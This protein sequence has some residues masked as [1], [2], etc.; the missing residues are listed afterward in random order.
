[1]CRL[2]YIGGMENVFEDVPEWC[3]TLTTAKLN[4]PE[5]S[6]SLILIEADDMFVWRCMCCVWIN[7]KVTEENGFPEIEFE[8]GAV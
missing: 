6:F 5:V 8:L 7:I 4:C 2:F 1:M 3:G